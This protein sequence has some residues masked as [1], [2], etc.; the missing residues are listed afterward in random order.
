MTSTSSPFR[1]AD[2]PAEIRTKIIS[3]LLP[4]LPV[5][6]H[7]SDWSPCCNNPPRM[8]SPGTWQALHEGA[9]YNFRSDQEPC[10]TAIL[11]ANKQLYEDGMQYLY[12][13]KTFKFTVWDYGFDYLKECCQLAKLPELPYHE[14]K[15]FVIHIADVYIWETGFRLR[16]NLVWICGL[17]RHHNIRFKSLKIEFM[18]NGRT[19]RWSEAWDSADFEEPGRPNRMGMYDWELPN[20]NYIAYDEWFP[21]TFAYM[22]TPLALLP[23]AESCVIEVPAELK[24]KQHIL[25]LAKW[26]EEG[27]DGTYE[28]PDDPTFV[29]DKA[30]FDYRLKHLDGPVPG[31]DCD[32][33]V[34]HFRQVDEDARIR[35]K[36]LAE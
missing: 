6:D 28:F 7:D 12:R 23:K 20:L 18:D 13:Q 19:H 17:L 25:D 34:S 21:S 24:G 29:A 14:M 16:E 11:R 3:F 30:E 35:A 32:E 10:Y 22:L 8:T 15:E 5:I 2:L 1:I 26:Y 31:C 33:C 9:P 4:D 27:I 36:W